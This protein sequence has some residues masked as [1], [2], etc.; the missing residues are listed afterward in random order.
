MI[1]R[2][3]R[4]LQIQPIEARRAL[5]L[6]GILFALTASYTLVKTARD[7]L[8]LAQLPAATLPYVYLAVGAFTAAAAALFAHGTRRHPARRS[9]EGASW[10]VA[11]SL[12]AFAPLLR[13]GARWVPIAFYLWVNVYGLILLSHFWDFTNSVSHPREAKRTFGIIGVGGILGGL[14]GGLVAPPL[15]RVASLSSLLVAAAILVALVTPRL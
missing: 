2:I 5:V 6:G 9:L 10:V 15:V 13:L 1:D 14:C 11:I 8:Y 3:A 4:A 7:A 12:A